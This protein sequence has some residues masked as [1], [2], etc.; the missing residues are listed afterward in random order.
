[1]MNA[2]LLSFAMERIRTVYLT[3][4]H[5]MDITVIRV[6]PTVIKEFVVFLTN[7]V[8]DY[9][10]VVIIIIFFLVPKI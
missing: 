7:S 5:E 9:L 4:M 3:H 8:K 1:M 6:N 10:D 2:T